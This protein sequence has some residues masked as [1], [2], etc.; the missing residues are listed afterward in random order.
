MRGLKPPRYPSLWEAIVNAVVFQ[1]VSL[2][3]AS[4]I[5]RR[6]ILELG[7]VVESRGS[8]LR[9]FPSAPVV[10]D[11]SDATLRVLGLSAAK[12]ATLRRVG[13][14]LES[15]KL[16]EGSLEEVSSAEASARLQGTKGIG[17]WTSS[18]VLLRGLGRLDVFPRGD[19]GVA[20]SLRQVAGPDIG[21]P[22]LLARLHPEQGMLYYHLLLAR[23]EASGELCRPSICE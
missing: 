5:V 8:H 13:D 10:L 18:V 20:R 1:Q 2:G 6:L 12:L 19:S 14:A 17:P 7:Q 22:M 16:S 21:L 11:A 15:G 23:L 4:A 9:V 3:A